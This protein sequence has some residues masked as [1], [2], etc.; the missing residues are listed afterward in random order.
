[1][2]TDRTRDPGLLEGLLEYSRPIMSRSLPVEALGGI[3]RDRVNMTEQPLDLT[4][5]DMRLFRRIVDALD[6]RPLKGDAT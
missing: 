4:R 2:G 6:Q 3:E 1:M 5:Q